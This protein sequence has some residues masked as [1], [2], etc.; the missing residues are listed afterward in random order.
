MQCRHVVVGANGKIMK[1]TIRLITMVSAALFMSATGARAADDW[2]DNLYLSADFGGVFQ[3][4]ASLIQNGSSANVTFN[5]GIRAD[6]D[7]GYKL[8]DS[9]AVE[10]ETGFMW[11]SMDK[12]NGVSF[13]SY[14]QSV[15]IYSVP[16][17]A[18]VIY[19]VPTETSW[20]PYFGV[21]VGGVVGIFDLNNTTRGARYSDTDLTF[22][23]QAEAGLDYALSKNASIG[24]AYKFL[25]TLNQHWLLS[26]K[27]PGD[28]YNHLML[29]GV[30]IHAVVVKF[31]WNF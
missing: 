9:W 21:G 22:A 11:N 27:L 12:I 6:I 4:E 19:K 20:T 16:L 2:S 31:T 15:D 26:P 14:S 29:D 3:Q 30:Y 5:P 8:N 18:N 28:T 25:G 7:L 10:L 1:T 13:S 24:I 23:Y 17:L